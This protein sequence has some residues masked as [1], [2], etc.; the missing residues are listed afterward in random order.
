VGAIEGAA[1]A[2]E[3]RQ[4]SNSNL[5]SSVFYILISLARRSLNRK[6]IIRM[7][8]QYS[9]EGVE[10]SHWMV[11]ER[12]SSMLEKKW[13]EPDPARRGHPFGPDYFRLLPRGRDV[14]TAQIERMDEMVGLLKTHLVRRS[15]NLIR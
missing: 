15:N 7:M 3:D 8:E 13:I 2:Q 12:L 4:E 14:I 1:I 11:Q 9:R 5:P 10:L 6:E